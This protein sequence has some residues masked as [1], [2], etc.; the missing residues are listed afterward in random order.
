[1]KR[2]V[3]TLFAILATLTA[4]TLLAQTAGARQDIKEVRTAI[5][6][7][8]HTQATGLPGQVEVVVGHLD[9]HMNLA[10]CVA[11]EA[12]L[13]KG[14]RAWGKTSVGVR[15]TAPIAWT[16]YVKASVKVHT[17]YVTA[18][19]P[20]TQGQILGRNDLV[21]TH[22]DLAA[23]PPGVVT[24]F[25]QAI[26]QKVS[27][28]IQLG[29]PIRKDLLRS[30]QAIQSGQAVRLVSIGQGFKVSTEGRAMGS[31]NDGQLIQTRTASGQT[32]SGIARMGGIVEVSF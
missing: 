8:L 7:F 2:I 11:P 22:G 9:P 3:H 27:M 30:Q 29:A 21:K 28:P 5:E 16:I 20:L 25:S 23:L 26:G 32:V 6:Q 18:A 24:D 13:P 19:V 10:A 15:C 17:E 31:A 4:S 12:F 14:S 1:M